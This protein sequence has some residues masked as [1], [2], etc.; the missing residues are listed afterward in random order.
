MYDNLTLIANSFHSVLIIFISIMF[1]L[2]WHTRE[3]AG[4]VLF[5]NQPM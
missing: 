2:Q 4:Q 1:H 3:L 5:F